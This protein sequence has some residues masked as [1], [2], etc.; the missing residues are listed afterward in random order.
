MALSNAFV[1][2]REINGRVIEVTAHYIAP[3]SV[4]GLVCKVDG[5]HVDLRLSDDPWQDAKTVIDTE[6]MEEVV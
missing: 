5:A 4:W 3:R 2:R 1:F 6:L